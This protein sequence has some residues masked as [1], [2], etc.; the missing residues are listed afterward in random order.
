MG[1]VDGHVFLDAGATGS[2]P[3]GCPAA[4]V[5]GSRAAVLRLQ[6]AS[7]R[8]YQ[9][10]DAPHVARRSAGHVALGLERPA[11]AQQ[12]QRQRHLSTPGSGAS[13][14]ASSPTTSASRR[15]PTAAARHGA[16]CSS[17]SSRRTASRARRQVAVAKWW[18]FNYG[19]ESQGDGVQLAA[20][21]LFRNYWQLDLT[22]GKSWNT[23]GRQADARRADHDPARDRDARARRS[24]PTSRRRFWATPPS[25]PQKREFG[26]RS[27]QV[28]ATL[29]LRPF[30]ALTLQATPYWLKV[31]TVAQYLQTV[32]DP[33]ADRDLRQPL[34]LRGLEQTEISI[35]LRLNLAL[36]PKLSLQ[37]YT[38]ALALG[39]RLPRDQGARGAAQLRLPGLRR[40]T[41]G[42]IARDP[43]RPFYTIDPTAGGEAR[44][45]PARGPRLQPQVAARERGPALGVPARLGR[46]PRLDR[47]PPG[48]PQPR[49]LSFG[50]DLG[51]S[52]RARPPTTCCW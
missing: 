14:R 46:L 12:E 43:E 51:R 42:T 7:Q 41:S 39:R 52:V 33:T 48:R 27:R 35:P 45:V 23:L 4:R 22:L 30:A 32:L 16:A 36:S 11:R 10:P 29:N 47:A 19:R 25:S 40:A 24:R 44:L 50:R 21:A 34:R 8:Y 5:S 1:G 6:R 49:R 31:D 17:A 38:Q 20:S 3:A 15:R 9:R 28:L 2:S 13:A 18:T 26:S 37:L